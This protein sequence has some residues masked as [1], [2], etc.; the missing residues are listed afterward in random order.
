MI[1]IPAIIRRTAESASGEVPWVGGAIAKSVEL[2]FRIALHAGVIA[3]SAKS[4]PLNM[5]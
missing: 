5:I 4:V 3:D 1:A 2:L